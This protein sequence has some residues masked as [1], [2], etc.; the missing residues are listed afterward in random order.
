MTDGRADGL[1]Q[2]WLSNVLFLCEQAG[3]EI[4]DRNVIWSLSGS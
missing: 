1:A 2:Q 4:P 3:L